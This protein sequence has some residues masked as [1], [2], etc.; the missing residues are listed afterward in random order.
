MKIKARLILAA[1][2]TITLPAQVLAHPGNHAELHAAEGAAHFMQ[3][4]FHMAG[5][6]AGLAIAAVVLWRLVAKR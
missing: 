6:A 5:V 4:P 1:A 2:A 3:S